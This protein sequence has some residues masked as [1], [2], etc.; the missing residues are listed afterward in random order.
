[1]LIG[2]SLFLT[3][4]VMHP[5]LNAIDHQAVQPLMH[6]QISTVQAIQRG[7]EPLREFMFNQVKAKDLSLFTS[8]AHRQPPATRADVLPTLVRDV[9]LCRTQRNHRTEGHGHDEDTIGA[10]DPPTAVWRD[11][12]TELT[13]G[14][15][16]GSL[17]VSLDGEVVQLETPLLYRSRPGALVVLG[18]P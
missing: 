7:E 3:I 13:I 14:T 6:H 5:T 8:L 15:P 11:E 4:F 18:P 17:P 12:P 9:Y 1:M 10:R 16:G 2:I